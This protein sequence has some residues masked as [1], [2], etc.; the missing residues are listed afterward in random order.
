MPICVFAPSRRYLLK[1]KPSDIAASGVSGYGPPRFGAPDV[2][3]CAGMCASE[4]ISQDGMD[5][6]VAKR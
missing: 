5:W 6:G 2:G 4:L 1:A 3:S